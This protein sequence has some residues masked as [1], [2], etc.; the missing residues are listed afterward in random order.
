MKYV[1]IALIVLAPS[2]ALAGPPTCKDLADRMPGFMVMPIWFEGGIKD[3]KDGV[4]IE[5]KGRGCSDDNGT[6]WCCECIEDGKTK[7]IRFSREKDSK[8]VVHQGWGCPDCKKQKQ[9]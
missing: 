6:T 5:C 2:F 3:I 4:E 1:L 9:P 8:S 7:Q